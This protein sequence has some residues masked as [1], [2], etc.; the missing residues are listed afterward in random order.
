LLSNAQNPL[1]TFPRNFPI[2]GEVTKLLPTCYRLVDYVTDLLA[3]QRGSRHILTDL[4]RG[5]WCS[6]FWP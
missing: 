6:G 3:T 5:N 2:D 1:D 4:L